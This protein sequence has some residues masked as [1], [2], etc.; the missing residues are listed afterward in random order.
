MDIGWAVGAM[1]DGKKVRRAEWVPIADQCAP[2]DLVT[3]TYLYYDQ[4]EGRVPSVLAMQ[5]DGRTAHF[6]MTHLHLLAE[7][8]EL[9]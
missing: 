3:W 8:W 5:S 2:I 6:P 7:D 9:V 1:K 4:S